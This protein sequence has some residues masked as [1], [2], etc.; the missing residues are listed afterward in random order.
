MR[1]KWLIEI[2]ELHAF[3]RAEATL[4]KS[5]ISRQVERYR[6]AYGRIEVHEPRQCLFIGTT[7][8]A[9]YLRDETGGRRFWPVKCGEIDVDG[10]EADRDQLFAEAVNLY[11]A[12]VPWWPD[13]AFEAEHI[14]PQQ[15]ERYEGDPWQQPISEHLTGVRKTTV[16]AVATNALGMKTD[17]I[18]T[19]DQRRIVAILKLLGWE[20]KRD[21][22]D[23]WWERG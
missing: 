21:N 19:A 2:A 5:F 23:R 13:R 11:Q 4:L 17:R 6:P 15:T 8:K 7:N 12:G 14:M 18:G 20:P 9:A 22:H 10:L 1:G 16:I 3:N